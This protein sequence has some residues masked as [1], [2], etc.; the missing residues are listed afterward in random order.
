MGKPQAHKCKS[1]TLSSFRDKN[2][3]KFCKNMNSEEVCFLTS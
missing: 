1:V 3:I 2:K